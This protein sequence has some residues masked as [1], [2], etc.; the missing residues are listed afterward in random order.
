MKKRT[1]RWTKLFALVV[2]VVMCVTVFPVTG[3]KASAEGSVSA[4]VA[5]GHKVG[6]K[7]ITP[8]QTANEV[9]AKATTKAITQPAPNYNGVF[10]VYSTY[11]F[12]SP[13][14]GG[15]Q[16]WHTSM[17]GL[18][19][20][21]IY[22]QYSADGGKTWQTTGR[23][24]YNGYTTASSIRFVIKGLRPN[25][26][27]VTRIYYGDGSYNPIS[28]FRYTTTF[29][30]G[31]PKAPKIK[32]VT[33]KAVKV[34]Y[35]KHRVRGHYEFTAM[36]Y[37]IWI[38]SYTE[39]Y[40]TY[41]LKVTVKLKKKSTAPG[42]FIALSGVG[43]KYIAG[44]KKTYTATFTPYPNYRTKRPPKGM[45]KKTV[46]IATYRSRSWGGYSPLTSR[47]RKVR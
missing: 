23:M 5:T 34:K 19:W 45:G 44:K 35:H 26:K 46:S 17:Y 16:N 29:V 20:D 25:T 4:A 31:Q 36:G 3:G 28:P 6:A 1:M 11:F 24:D 14:G 30:T 8:S 18:Y 38:S 37:P 7:D 40:Y 33:V 21:P 12:Y 9:S 13:F 32:K 39:R 15:N 43:S 10:D 2:A 22:L 47:K 41:K 42:M 27:Y